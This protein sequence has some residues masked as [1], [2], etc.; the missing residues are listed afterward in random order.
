MGTMRIGV[1]WLGGLMSGVALAQDEADAS[2]EADD[3]D[4]VVV[5]GTRTPRRLGDAPVAV[6]VIDRET[7]DA[8]GAEDVADVL[9]QQPGVAVDR[10][11]LGA[12]VRL[13]GL[14]AEHTLILV[15]GQRVVGRKDG[16]FDLSRIS[17]ESIER[18]EIVKGASSALYGSDAMGG[19]IH[20]ITRRAR[21]PLE[22]AIHLRGGTLGV[23][24]VSGGLAARSRRRGFRIDGGCHGNNAYDLDPSDVAT[25]GNGNGQC[26]VT[27]SGDLQP[28]D[29][30][31]LRASGAY[32][33]IDGRGVDIDTGGGAVLDRRNVTEDA[34]ARVQADWLFDDKSRWSNS[35]GLSVF[36]DQFLLDQREASGLDD[37]QETQELLLQ[38]TSQVDRVM[39]AHVV[40]LG[41]EGFA[42]EIQSDRLESGRGGR[43]RGG[44]YVQ[45]EIEVASKPRFVV[46]PGVRWDGDTWFGGAL[47]PK[48]GLRFDPVDTLTFRASAGSGWRAPAFRELL[49]NFSNPGVGYVV[50]GNFDLRP[51]RSVGGSV[52]LEWQP[53]G[54]V[55]FS[56]SGWIDRVQDLIQITTLEQGAVTQ[57]GYV[58]VAEARTRGLET[59]ASLS[60]PSWL[61]VDV[62][63]TLTDAV[64]VASG[65]PLE[66]RALLQGTAAL[67]L[68]APGAFGPELS[69]RAVGFGP[70]PFY[71]DPNAPA[72][73]ISTGNPTDGIREDAP[74]YA[75]LDLKIT[76][77]LRRDGKVQVFAGAE[78]LLNAFDARFL[79]NQPRFLYGG[80]DVRWARE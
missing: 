20:I 48:L 75:L 42:S 59:S 39:G 14:N 50:V 18:I 58:N 29:D 73:P 13:R 72:G 78:N 38:I 7:I 69:T 37:Y 54:Q 51:E 11:V 33:V 46:V 61:H 8:S 60:A 65:R 52:G 77:P 27:L 80:L 2:D 12:A 15:D 68:E 55:S 19:V 35:V 25:N 79:P 24:D 32:S 4:E 53:A 28:T 66:G 31:T 10:G 44:V 5:T 30:L 67:R 62:S 22:G 56:L 41:V 47:A 63:G 40:S 3:L 64:D 26:D 76:Q 36:R 16:T 57:F 9:E 43:Q 23:F 21:E 17:A 74:P 71:R 6:E 45:D 1:L 49:L 70:R 34:L